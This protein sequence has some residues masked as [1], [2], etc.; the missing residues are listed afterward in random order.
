MKTQYGH[1]IR[2]AITTALLGVILWMMATM[3][4][5]RAIETED[6][7][8]FRVPARHSIQTDFVL[9]DGMLVGRKPVELNPHLFFA[10]F[11]PLGIAAPM[12]IYGKEPPAAPFQ[13]IESTD[14]DVPMMFIYFDALAQTVSFDLLVRQRSIT[15]G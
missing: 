3:I 8:G 9:Y 13:S 6:F 1:P 15:I 11:G 10:S 12:L 7:S 4:A 2:V 5:A 14:T